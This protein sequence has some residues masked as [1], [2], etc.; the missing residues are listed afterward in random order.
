MADSQES[1]GEILLQLDRRCCPLLD[2]I[3]IQENLLFQFWRK[4]IPESNKTF[5]IEMAMFCR[6][7]MTV[8]FT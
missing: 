7:G 2:D 1:V 5:A 8:V 6:C 3:G 4:P